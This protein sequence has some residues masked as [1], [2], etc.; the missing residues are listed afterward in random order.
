MNSIE[1]VICEEDLRQVIWKEISTWTHPRETFAKHINNP[2]FVSEVF[3]SIENRVNTGQIVVQREVDALHDL[4]NLMAYKGVTRLKDLDEESFFRASIYINMMLICDIIWANEAIWTVWQ[5]H[6]YIG[7]SWEVMLRWISTTE[8]PWSKFETSRIPDHVLE[9]ITFDIVGL[10]HVDRD[11][12]L[13]NIKIN[14]LYRSVHA[15][16]DYV[17]ANPHPEIV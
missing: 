15:K 11:F 12:S 17:F 10:D 3:K 1:K 2:N 8:R 5:Y 16:I 7:E 4:R 13:A 14:E 6:L 9:E